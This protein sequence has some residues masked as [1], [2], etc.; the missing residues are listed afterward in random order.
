MFSV[1]PRGWCLR[2]DLLERTESASAFPVEILS[3]SNNL[4][5]T[6]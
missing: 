5:K 3:Q 4:E 6:A 2:R 1:S